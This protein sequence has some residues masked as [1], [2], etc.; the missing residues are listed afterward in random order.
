[1]DMTNV[2][3]GINLFLKVKKSPE[4]GVVDLS[5]QESTDILMP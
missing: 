2:I 3:T 4:G 1:M 5:E